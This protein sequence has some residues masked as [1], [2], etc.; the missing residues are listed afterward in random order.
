MKEFKISLAAM[1]I[2]ISCGI[3]ACKKTSSV[4]NI[5][6]EP[7][8]PIPPVVTGT[9]AQLTADSIFLYA[10]ELYYWRA[11]LPE[12]AAFN[13]R[14]YSD[15]DEELYA[16]TQIAINPATGFPYEYVPDYPG[17]KY[18][19]IDYSVGGGKKSSLKSAV[20]GTEI[21]YGFSVIFNTETD[22]RVNYV[23]PNSPADK[24]GLTRG[25]RI[26]AVN[27][28]S[29]VSYSQGNVTFLN[30]AFFG[31][32]PTIELKFTSLSGVSKTVTITRTSY[33][34]NPILYSH[35]FTVGT[36]KV[37][38]FV[39][40]S[41]SN[42]V[43]AAINST[44]ANFASNGV[45]EMV[46]DL[47]YNG[48]GYVSTAT[49]IINLLAPVTQ[50]GNTM[51]T[52]YYNNYLQNLTTEQRKA[53]IL[54]HQPNLDAS[55]NLQTSTSA[56]NG[57]YFSFADLDY[58]ATAAENIEKFAKSGSLNV[59]RIY[60][61]VT[62]STASASELTINSLKPVTDVKLIGTT[63]YG[64]PV[65][66]FPVRID[67]FDMYIPEFETKNQR[68]VGGY[69][70]GLTVDKESFEDPTKNWGDSTETLLSYALLYSKTGSFVT[71]P[72]K[73]GSLAQQSTK[74]AAKLS[75]QELRTVSIALDQN[76]FKGMIRD[77]K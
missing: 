39:F 77:K 23:N 47:R 43:S 6:P 71:P 4:P 74:L 42:N 21:D 54:T 17:P 68:N 53:S 50:N 61:L 35:I 37:G 66:F 73:S 2:I 22:L 5:A 45:D 24:A 58:S 10:K 18:S 19:Y 64:K 30:D 75:R 57:Q 44:F 15:T 48:G 56:I 36:K 41:F 60:F 25:C 13:P 29:D 31:T 46:I 3:L 59:S 32:N 7:M 11:N 49:Q 28:Q 8:L 67:D 40:N 1:A 27:G 12:Y 33:T 38:Y 76:A 63:T 70:S 9:R 52:Y 34:L 20:N 72:S 55:G 16:L 14:S 65:G 69:Y 26:N 51:F 62:G